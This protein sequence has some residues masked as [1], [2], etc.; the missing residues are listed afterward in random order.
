MKRKSIL[1]LLVTFCSVVW[2]DDLG[3][4]LIQASIVGDLAEVERLLEKQV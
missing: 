3:H 2:S 4:E 1:I